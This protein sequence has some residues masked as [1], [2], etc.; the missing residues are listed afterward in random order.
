MEPY[1]TIVAGVHDTERGLR[2]TDRAIEVAGHCRAILYLAAATGPSHAS[3]PEST[4]SDGDGGVRMEPASPAVLQRLVERAHEH[5]VTDARPLSRSGRPVD[6]LVDV[7]DDVDAGLVVVGSHGINTTAGRVFGSVAAD[8]ARRASSDVLIVHTTDERW[9]LSHA[10][11]R[12]LGPTTAP[13]RRVLVGVHDSV[14]DP[15]STQRV[16]EVGAEMAAIF[17]AEIVLSSSYEP[18]DSHE[19]DRAEMDLGSDAAFQL[20]GANP[21]EAALRD[22]TRTAMAVGAR[23]PRTVARAHTPPARALVEQ[24]G[25]VGADL[26]VV[27][28]H[29]LHARRRRMLGAVAA[30]VFRHTPADVLVVNTERHRRPSP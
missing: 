6:V 23:S 5:G 11:R 18:A 13:Y 4:G 15:H 10:R 29:G 8:S 14:R 16:V 25:Q 21:V 20:R 19:V 3:H 17:D 26:V 27:G 30:S 22:A 1:R 9:H 7:A 24:A 28:S 2:A 12:R